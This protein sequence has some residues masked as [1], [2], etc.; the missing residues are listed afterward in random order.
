MELLVCLSGYDMKTCVLQALGTM[1]DPSTAVDI[2]KD[3]HRYLWGLGAGVSKGERTALTFVL[4]AQSR[5]QRVLRGTA[6]P[7]R[8]RT[9]GLGTGLAARK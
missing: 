9:A 5:S 6:L 8:R 1:Y 7:R 4:S 3:Y 2:A